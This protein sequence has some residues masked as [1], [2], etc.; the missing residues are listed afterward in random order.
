MDTQTDRPSRALQWAV[1]MFGPDVAMNP[2]ERALRFFEEAAE[3]AHTMGAPAKTLQAVIGRVFSRE[4]GTIP[5]ELGQAQMTLEVL[6]K[7]LGVDLDGEAAKEFQRV[8]SIPKVE[9]DRRHAAKVA[10]GIAKA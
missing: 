6:A 8:Q 10:I 7:A 4:A 9:W 5:R 3:V 2:H 1:D